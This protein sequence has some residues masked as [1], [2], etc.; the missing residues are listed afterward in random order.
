MEALASKDPAIICDGLRALGERRPTPARV[1]AVEAQLDSKFQ[2]VQSVAAQVLAAWG[3]H[4]SLPRL[5]ATFDRL[6]ASH[7]Y[8]QRA[9]IAKAMGA[10]LRASDTE[11][12]IDWFLSLPTYNA[13]FELLPTVACVDPKRAKPLLEKA[14]SVGDRQMKHSILVAAS[15]MGQPWMFIPSGLRDPDGFIRELA[16]EFAKT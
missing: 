7:L 12:I 6:N 3:S 10:V 2:S 11:G 5:R 4:E 1:A 16:T 13:R 8:A 15:E 9:I 14:W